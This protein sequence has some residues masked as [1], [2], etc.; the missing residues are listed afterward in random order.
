MI[1][2]LR[3]PR[4][5]PYALV[6]QALVAGLA[7]AALFDL[8]VQPLAESLK[9]VGAQANV[10]VLVTPALV[11]G[12]QAPALKADLPVTGVLARLLEGTGLEYHFVNDQTVVIRERAP[13]ES[14]GGPPP[15]SRSNDDEAT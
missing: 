15:G 2:S 1:R 11:D 7:H 3:T 12:K 4:G 8:P 10:N 5:L 14:S 6:L 13:A 9:A